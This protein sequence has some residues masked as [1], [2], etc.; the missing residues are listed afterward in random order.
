MSTQREDQEDFPLRP[1]IS[2][3]KRL[4]L[5]S[6]TRS[7]VSLKKA[8]PKAPASEKQTTVES[9]ISAAAAAPQYLQ[10]AHRQ[11]LQNSRKVPNSAVPKGITQELEE[12]TAGVNS[13]EWCKGQGHLLASCSNDKKVFVWDVFGSKSAVLK[14]SHHS[15]AVKCVCW[16]WDNSLLLCGSYDRTFSLTDVSTGMLYQVL[17]ELLLISL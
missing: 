14:I 10:V 5:S 4:R 11:M 3:R 12:H 7:D 1:Y 17:F 9:Q 13:I 6:E 15:E 8:C 16:N 2:K